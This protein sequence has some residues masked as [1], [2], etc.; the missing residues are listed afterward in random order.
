MTSKRENH[1]KK[2][3][4]HLGYVRMKSSIPKTHKIILDIDNVL[5]KPYTPMNQ[6]IIKSSKSKKQRSKSSKTKHKQL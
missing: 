6:D 4:K 3:A 2:L 1:S 5:D